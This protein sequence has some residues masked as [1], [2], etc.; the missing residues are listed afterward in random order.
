MIRLSQSA[1]VALI[2]VAL[3]LGT[4]C[5]MFSKGSS[6]KPTS[7]KTV[8]GLTH[9]ETG[10][11]EAIDQIDATIASMQA[12]GT[13]PDFLADA[14]KKYVKDVDALDSMAKE[15]AERNQALRA[16]TQAYF[17]TW[18]NESMEMKSDAV[19]SISDERRAA[20]R[21]SFD[22]MRSEMA[23]GKAAFTPL[24]DQ[25]RDIQLYLTNDLTPA[26][27]TACKPIADQAVANS[28]T[29]KEAL[30]AMKGDL[31]RVRSELSAKPAAAPAK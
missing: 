14:F 10:V 3:A 17:N 27:V 5:S 2:A 26:G 11:Q 19:K 15:A 8:E 25:L 9:M 24:M 4:G 21:A 6:S 31:A 1:A 23:K 12:L 28:K 20:A 16:K 18:E 30:T 13:N 7:A 22:K 29:V